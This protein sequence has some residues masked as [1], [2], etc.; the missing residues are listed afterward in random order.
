MIALMTQFFGE[1]LELPEE[2][3]YVYVCPDCYER[4]VAPHSDALRELLR[5][6]SHPRDDLPGDE[7]KET[8]ERQ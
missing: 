8:P 1:I 4:L 3:G 6:H 2:P 7:A 5:A